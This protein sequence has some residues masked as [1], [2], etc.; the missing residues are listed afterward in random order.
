ML[1]KILLI[2]LALIL[3][4]GSAAAGDCHLDIQ[5]AVH[6]GTDESAI[7]AEAIIREKEI[8]ILS[9]LFPSYA[10]SVES[11]DA[12]VPSI[13]GFTGPFEPFRMPP[14]KEILT[15]FTTAMNSE[16]TNGFFSGDLF[17]ES[18]TMTT[19]TFTLDELI[20]AFRETADPEEAGA[21]E[22]REKAA[23]D[24]LQMESLQELSKIMIRC[25][26]YDG[27]NYVTLNG[28]EED[29]TLFTASCDFNDPLAVKTVFGYP[30]SGKNYYA[31]SIIKVVSDNEISINSKMISDAQKLGYR[32]VMNNPPV[33]SENWNIKLSENRKEISF[34]GEIIPGNEKK[35]VEIAGKIS[36]ENKTLLM[37]KIGFKNWEESWFTLAVSLDDTPVNTESLKIITPDSA[38]TMSFLGEISVNAM[39]FLTTLNQALPED[40]HLEL[41]PMN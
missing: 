30:D 28:L 3:M 9:G 16:T 7:T 1:K 41:L 36:T 14:V 27:G 29:R 37:A 21:A 11:V 32:T 6:H 24:I 31:V 34:T 8:L 39:T 33:L 35:T 10:L 12:E 22:I 15:M 25:N 4:V 5:F 18:R 40:Y 38:D 17:E 19:C 20:N 26:L 23:G 13:D 2:L